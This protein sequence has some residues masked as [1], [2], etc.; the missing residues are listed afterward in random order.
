MLE[1]LGAVMTPPSYQGNLES[2][3]GVAIYVLARDS[4]E[5]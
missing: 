3:A 2:D 4:G 1:A 5:E